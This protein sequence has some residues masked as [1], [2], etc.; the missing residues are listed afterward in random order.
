M[1]LK[2]KRIG[3]VVTTE[4]SNLLASSCVLT[5]VPTT[6]DFIDFMNQTYPKALDKLKEI[7]EK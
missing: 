6:E 2:G 5:K 1:F 4:I 7:C 3:E